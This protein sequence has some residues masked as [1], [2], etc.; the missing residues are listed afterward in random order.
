MTTTAIV[1]FATAGIM[2][3]FCAIIVTIVWRAK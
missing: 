2:L 3:T 1:F